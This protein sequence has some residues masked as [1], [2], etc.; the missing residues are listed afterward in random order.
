[1]DGVAFAANPKDKDALADLA[2]SGSQA[3][4]SLGSIGLAAL[5]IPGARPGAFMLMKVGDNIGKV[6]RIWN[7][8]GKFNSTNKVKQAQNII[9]QKA[10]ENALTG[11]INTT[12]PK[13]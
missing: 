9:N 5:P 1:M 10:T 4:L 8:T 6:E 11:S 12:R 2:L 7:L 3:L 13:F